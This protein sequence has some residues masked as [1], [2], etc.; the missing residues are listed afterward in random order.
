MLGA[1]A[2]VSETFTRGH[3]ESTL[4]QR[5]YQH[6]LFEPLWLFGI[7]QMVW[8]FPDIRTSSICMMI[9]N[10]IPS[11]KMLGLVVLTGY[12]YVSRQKGPRGNFLGNG[13]DGIS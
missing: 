9:L 3:L 5:S 13:L 7:S 1:A 8:N 2:W 10:F 12:Q 4:N 11:V 6:R